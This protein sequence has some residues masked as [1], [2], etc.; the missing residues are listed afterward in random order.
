MATDLPIACSLSADE[1]A[2]R[3]EEMRALARDALMDKSRAPGF[4]KLEFRS[5]GGTDAAVH[6]L[7]RRERE[8]C[9]FLDIAVE[10]AGERIVVSIR[11]PGEA[12]PVLDAIYET[13]V[14]FTTP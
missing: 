4:V 5:G 14:R 9:P 13:N 1:M 8:C 6:E 10:R 2:R 3:G 7:V 12:Q 11:G